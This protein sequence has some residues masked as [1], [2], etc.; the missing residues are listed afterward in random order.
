M[1]NVSLTNE[2]EELIMAIRNYRKSYPDGYPQLLW[3]C[4]QCF[5]NLVDLP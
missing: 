4:Q 2:E 1:K 5:D 3:Y